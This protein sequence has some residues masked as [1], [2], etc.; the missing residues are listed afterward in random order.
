MVAPRGDVG[1]AEEETHLHLAIAASMADGS[2]SAGGGVS[3]IGAAGGSAC[4]SAGSS[5]D[6]SAGGRA[7]SGGEGPGSAAGVRPLLRACCATPWHVLTCSSAHT[8]PSAHGSTITCMLGSVMLDTGVQAPCSAHDKQA[9]IDEVLFSAYSHAVDLIRLA[10]AGR[11][12]ARQ[13]AHEV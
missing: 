7:G 13:G 2:G 5:A 12:G 4:S 8:L 9:A 6:S 3:A 10:S 11:R 1:R